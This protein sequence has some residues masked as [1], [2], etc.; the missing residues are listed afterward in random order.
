MDGSAVGIDVPVVGDGGPGRA[1][2]FSLSLNPAEVDGP[3]VLRAELIG[4]PGV[5]GSSLCGTTGSTLP[6]TSTPAGALNGI[7]RCGKSNSSSERVIMRG[8]GG[9]GVKLRRFSDG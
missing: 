9:D 7:L 3:G 8:F 6:L 1:A 2:I 5:V 4:I